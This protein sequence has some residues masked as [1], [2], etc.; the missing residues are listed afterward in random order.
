[1]G[2]VSA[3]VALAIM[4]SIGTIILG[5]TTFDCSELNKDGNANWSQ[6]CLDSAEGAIDGYG[7]L[8]IILI[9]VAAVAIL[10]VVRTL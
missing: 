5:N 2:V 1:M 8:I 6:A 3:F 9:I 7:L 10:A 4:L